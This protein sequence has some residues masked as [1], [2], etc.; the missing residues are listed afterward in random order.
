M[1]SKLLLFLFYV[2]IPKLS[3]NSM[4]TLFA[5]HPGVNVQF[6]GCVSLTTGSYH[7]LT[8]QS[9]ASIEYNFRCKAKFTK[10]SVG[11]LL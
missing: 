4:L 3:H 2:S 5:E 6:R 8:N 7:P 10:W 1:S 9:T 11:P